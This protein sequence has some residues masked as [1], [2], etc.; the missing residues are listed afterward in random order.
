[1]VRLV[2]V[3]PWGAQDICQLECCDSRMNPTSEEF[4]PEQ[5]P[6]AASTSE[7]IVPEPIVPDGGT[8]Y[9]PVPDPIPT[10]RPRP[11]APGLPESLLWSVAA[12]GIQIVGLLAVTVAMMIVSIV[13]SDVDEPGKLDADR[14][15][16]AAQEHLVYAMIGGGIGIGLLSMAGIL[17]RARPRGMRRLGWHA[18][19]ACHVALL[20]CGVVPLS[21]LCSQLATLLV[22]WL[23]GADWGVGKMFDEIVQ[24]PLPVS[25]LAIAIVP[26]FS[27]ELLFRGLIGRGL[28]ARWGL[29]PGMLL[30]SFLFGLIHVA[31]AQAVAVIPLGLAIH[32]VYYTTRSF[33]GPILVHLFNNAWATFLLK[34]G[35]HAPRNF[36]QLLAADVDLPIDLLIMSL[37]AVLSI[38]SL[39]GQTRVSYRLPD[40]AEWFPGYATAEVPPVE[41]CATAH[42][43]TAS[44]GLLICLTLS[45][46]G[47]VAAILRHVAA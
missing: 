37:G 44:P 3:S 19:R 23:P 18:P 1:M 20:L 40:K 15:E 28:L 34:F 45:L 12:I 11:P 30:T 25:L 17:W 10:A 32:W 29:W 2:N 38:A 24:A 14:I 13:L 33:W 8:V 4:V 9:G 42:R 46:L 5:P 39:L 41:S 43:G 36:E 47:V 22:K 6:L 35:P 27:E 31:P 26:A 16:Q 21:L 7:T